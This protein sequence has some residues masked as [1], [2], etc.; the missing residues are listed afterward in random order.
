MSLNHGMRILEAATPVVPAKRI[1]SALPVVIGTAPSWKTDDH[2]TDA[3]GVPVIAYDFAE[4][5]SFLGYSSTWSDYTLCEFMKAFHQLY[6]LAPCVYVNAFDPYG[7]AS[8]R[9]A[10]ANV[11]QALAA[12]VLTVTSGG[13]AVNDILIDNVVV[14]SQDGATTYDLTE[15]YTI[16]YDDDWHVVIT[17]VADGDIP[18]VDTTLKILYET[19]K[20]SGVTAAEI[21]TAIA[22]VEE[23][24]PRLQIVPGQIV[25]PKWSLTASVAA[26][27]L[28]QA[29]DIDDSFKCTALVDISTAADKADLYSEVA[30]VKSAAGYT[31]AHM[32]CC[33]P[34]Y[35]YDAETY[36]AST[37]QACVTA[38][39]DYE[40]NGIPYVSPSNKSMVIDGCKVA[41]GTAVYLSRAQANS[42]NEVGVVTALHWEGTWR[43]WGNWTA[44]F[45]SGTDPK[46]VQVPVRRMF[47][48]LGNTIVASFFSMVDKPL[49]RRTVEWFENSVNDW[50]AGLKATGAI[51]LGE[52]TLLESDNPVTNL[53]AGSV[54][55]RLNV[56]PVSAASDIAITL[57]IDPTAYTVLWE[58][59]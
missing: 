54:M 18:A 39:T 20:P 10:Q 41:A 6:G 12:G 16:A 11:D 38:R 49:N 26:A 4:A 2:R 30:G 14:K 55:F 23:V 9:N 21:V 17:R 24:Y 37:H 35:T 22:Q 51:L 15:D 45:V 48:F 42:L 1:S 46:D 27:M 56:T 33:W 59:A 32:L 40:N 53:E 19:A 28:A 31:D 50:L 3:H 13:N 36:Y 44:A 58:D 8:H 29:K 57:A 47:D 5:E 43:S 25:A 52:V 7:N 34:L